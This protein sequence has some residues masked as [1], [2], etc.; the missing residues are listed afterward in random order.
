VTAPR[1]FGRTAMAHAVMAAPQRFA[2][3]MPVLAGTRPSYTL[4]ERKKASRARLNGSYHS[5]ILSM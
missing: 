4:R 3:P 2:L 5:R 1:T